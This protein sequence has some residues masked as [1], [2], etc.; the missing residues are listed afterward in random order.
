MPRNHR[1]ERHL[2]PGLLPSPSHHRTASTPHYPRPSSH[3]SA[4]RLWPLHVLLA[5]V[6]PWLPAP[7]LGHAAL[8]RFALCTRAAHSTSHSVHATRLVPK[9]SLALAATL[10]P[11][12]RDELPDALHA[13]QGGKLIR[14]SRHALL[15][16][17]LADTLPLCTAHP[18]PHALQLQPRA[19]TLEHRV[20][21]ACA[22]LRGRGALL[23]GL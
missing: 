20:Q 9:P 10:H 2:R 19:R 22:P 12:H 18:A 14:D 4:G 5:P 13:R 3:G 15:S 8:L 1:C 23:E 6:A 7:T 17:L 16:S 11:H 21:R